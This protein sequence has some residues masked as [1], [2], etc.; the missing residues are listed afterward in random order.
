MRQTGGLFRA[1]TSAKSLAEHPHSS[2]RKFEAIPGPKGPAGIG[3][4]IYYTKFS[5][6]YWNLKHF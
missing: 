1:V 6:M 5:G 4:W 2:L 3:S